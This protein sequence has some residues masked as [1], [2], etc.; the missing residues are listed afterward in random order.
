MLDDIC[1]MQSALEIR[2]ASAFGSQIS[3]DF[4]IKEAKEKECLIIIEVIE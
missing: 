3:H 4:K 2:D 1:Y